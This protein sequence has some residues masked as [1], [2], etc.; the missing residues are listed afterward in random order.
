[1]LHDV[2]LNESPAS[3]FWDKIT[4]TDYENV[5]WPTV[6]MLGWY[7]IL[8][9]G[10]LVGFDG[11]QTQSLAPG[12]HRLVVDPLGHCQDGAW[13]FPSDELVEGRSLIAVMMAMEEFGVDVFRAHDSKDAFTMHRNFDKVTFY[14]MGAF[15]DTSSPGHYWTSL[16]DFPEYTPTKYYLQTGGDATTAKPPAG[17]APAFYVSDPAD[18]VPSIGGSA[19]PMAEPYTC[20]PE[21]R[22]V[23]EDRDDVLVFTTAPLD[24]PLTLTGPIDATLFVESDAPDVDFMVSI[25]DVDKSGVS[26]IVQNSAQR[27]KW[28]DNA[29]NASAPMETGTVYPVHL[30]LWNTSHVFDVG[31]QIRFTVASSDY[32]RISVNR[33]NGALLVDEDSLSAVVATNKV[34]LSEDYP[35]FV[36]LPVV[37]L[38]TDLP[39]TDAPLKML[40]ELEAQGEDG[41]LMIKRAER[42]LA[43][44][45]KS[46]GL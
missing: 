12:Q 18:P 1:M 16:P 2:K 3:A 6:F 30:S 21:D 8:L 13:A 43:Q 37:D 14:V 19:L 4:Y 31:H 28:R 17:A 5:H 44:G 11:Y 41:R 42:L 32:P 45:L 20:G 46:M 10:G 27:M 22:K 36:T 38:D 24:A 25:T 33:Q 7:D 39:P 35:S 29:L 26:R 34:H 9:T 15:N 40:A 23:V